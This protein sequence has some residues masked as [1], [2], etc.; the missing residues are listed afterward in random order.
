VREILDRTEKIL[1]TEREKSKEPQKKSILREKLKE[2]KE[3]GRDRE[4]DLLR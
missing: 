1:S 3:K 2:A 4:D